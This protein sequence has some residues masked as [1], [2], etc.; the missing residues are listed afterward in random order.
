MFTS[1]QGMAATDA[2]FGDKEV[3]RHALS[4]RDFAIN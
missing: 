4:I 2:E 3:S 1:A